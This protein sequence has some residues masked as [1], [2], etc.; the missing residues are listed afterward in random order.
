MAK[1][2]RKEQI[3]SNLKGKKPGNTPLTDPLT[4]PQARNMAKSEA[5]AEYGPTIRAAKADKRGSVQRQKNIG[6]WFEGLN[7][8][9]GEAGTQTDASYNQANAALL[10]HM[11]AAQAAAAG[12]QSQIAQS[13]QAMTALTGADPSLTTPALQEG[14]AAA[15]QR[16]IAGAALAAPIAQAGA[17]QAAYLRNTGINTR[18][19]GISQKLGEAKRRDTIKQDI[20]ALRKERAGKAI[21]NF[22]DIRGE[23][24]DY[25]IQKAAFGLDKKTA[26]AD[27]QNAAFD[28]SIAARNAATAERNAATTEKNAAGGGNGGMTPAERRDAKQGKVAAMVTAK[29]LYSAAKKPPQTPAEWAAFTQLIA[30]EDEISPQEA[31]WA[32]KRLRQQLGNQGVGAGAAQGGVHR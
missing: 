17:G 8:Q 2:S 20:T 3:K 29:N 18:R 27:A 32:V 22:R 30:A 10:A 14:A 23:E 12:S 19:E 26:A 24:R 7:N 4:T 13:N 21:G 16:N 11:N 9:I 6:Q 31:Q 5:R 28:N 1:Q 15:N 25:G